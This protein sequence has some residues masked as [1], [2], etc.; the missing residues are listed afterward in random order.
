MAI[1]KMTKNRFLHGNEAG[2]GN[3]QKKKAFDRGHAIIK[4]TFLLAV[5]TWKFSA[6]TYFRT[7]NS[8]LSSI[9]YKNERLFLM[10]AQ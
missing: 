8:N 9:F 7:R 2:H 5:W 6:H 1:G 3:L 4:V 10:N